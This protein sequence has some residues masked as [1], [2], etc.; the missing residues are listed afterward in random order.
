MLDLVGRRKAPRPGCY[1]GASHSV[2]QDTSRPRTI[3]RVSFYMGKDLR[4]KREKLHR[5]SL[6]SNGT[7]L[8]SRKNKPTSHICRRHVTK[9]QSVR[10]PFVVYI[11]HTLVKWGR[12]GVPKNTLRRPW[13]FGDALTFRNVRPIQFQLLQD[14]IRITQIQLAFNNHHRRNQRSTMQEFLCDST[15]PS[16]PDRGTVGQI[17]LSHV[18]PSVQP[19]LSK[20]SQLSWLRHKL[21]HSF[22]LGFA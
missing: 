21:Q 14:F 19:R 6:L 17:N 8:R 22:N 15:T 10:V 4:K 11:I 7:V 3:N 16:E 20:S 9:I 13:I 1:T 5:N 12:N 18:L 2:W